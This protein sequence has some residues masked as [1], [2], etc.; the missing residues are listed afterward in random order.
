MP[1]E[2]RR[3]AKR[4]ISGGRRRTVR[5]RAE[6]R[7]LAAE[8]TDPVAHDRNEIDADAE[9]DARR[10]DQLDSR[11]DQKREERAQ[12]DVKRLPDL[13]VVV[14]EFAVGRPD[15]QGCGRYFRIGAEIGAKQSGVAHY[16]AGYDRNEAADDAGQGEQQCDDREKDVHRR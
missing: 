12:P 15:S 7:A 14:D 1:A 16:R 5:G 10:E 8:R 2:R 13:P 9:E 4:A 11:A 3:F 6:R